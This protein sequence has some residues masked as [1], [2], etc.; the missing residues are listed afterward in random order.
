MQ[1]PF[2]SAQEGRPSL[3]GDQV[4][5]REY[6][7]LTAALTA[8]VVRFMAN[9]GVV[10]DGN[11]KNDEEQSYLQKQS[12]ERR[13]AVSLVLLRSQSSNTFVELYQ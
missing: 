3:V 7:S 6:S 10:S 2:H 11:P 13:T 4:R 5:Y 1:D 8:P 9:F 12:L